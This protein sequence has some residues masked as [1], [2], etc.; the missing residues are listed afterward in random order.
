MHKFIKIPDK[1]KKYI[2]EFTGMFT[3]PSFT[4][5]SQLMFA[6]PVCDKA[7]KN[8]YNLYGYYLAVEDKKAGSSY[9][10]FFN[11]ARWDEDLLAERKADMFFKALDVR[12]NDQIL[13]IV[14]DTYEEK[15][16]NN[17]EGVWKVFF[18]IIQEAV[19]SEGKSFYHLGYPM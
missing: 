18:M 5:F 12:R 11:D 1:L 14:D 3:K 4:S 2:D 16:G 13:F 7:K 19:I 15:K 6:I 8:V 17:T 9:N 10:W